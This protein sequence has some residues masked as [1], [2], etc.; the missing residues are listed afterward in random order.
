MLLHGN[1]GRVDW[2]VDDVFL[3]DRRERDLGDQL[4]RNT[5]H[6]HSRGVLGTCR[7]TARWCLGARD[8]AA[9][10]VH[11]GGLVH[12]DVLSSLS[13]GSP[14]RG[15]QNEPDADE[16]EFT[17][18][19]CRRSVDTSPFPVA[20]G[21]RRFRRSANRPIEL[22]PRSAVCEGASEMYCFTHWAEAED[23]EPDDSC[24][25]VIDVGNQNPRS[26]GPMP[27]YAYAMAA[28]AAYH[29]EHGRR[30]SAERSPNRRSRRR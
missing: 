17:S 29:R 20:S 1:D 27:A 4:S 28:A 25:D 23:H 15:I 7:P 6:P 30:R 18:C 5:N 22:V 8:S 21:A 3:S 2:R 19:S 11:P 24:S 14:R 13:R 26:A 12:R 10:I 9:R 16:A